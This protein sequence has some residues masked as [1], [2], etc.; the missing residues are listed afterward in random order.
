MSVS[1]DCLPYTDTY[2]KAFRRKPISDLSS[3][4]SFLDSPKTMGEHDECI[5]P[6]PYLKDLIL[7]HHPRYDGPRC[8]GFV[9]FSSLELKWVTLP[10]NVSLRDTLTICQMLQRSRHQNST[11]I[12]RAYFECLNGWVKINSYCHQ[13]ISRPIQHLSCEEARAVCKGRFSFSDN[14]VAVVQRTLRYFFEWLNDPEEELLYGG[15]I[16]Y[17]SVVQII[18]SITLVSVVKQNESMKTLPRATICETDFI[19]VEYSCSQSQSACGDGSCILQHYFCDGKTDCPDDSD[20]IDCHHVCLFS[21]EVRLSN[22]AANCYTDCHY[23]N[24]SCHALYYQCHIAGGCIPASRLCDGKADCAAQEDESECLDFEYGIRATS[25]SP[26]TFTCDDG[27][28]IPISQVNDLIPDC[29]GGNGEDE[30]KMKLYWSGDIVQSP[31][32]YNGCP[33]TYTQC[34]KGLLGVCYPRHKLCVYEVDMDGMQIK[35][36]RNAAHLSNCSSHE[37]PSM[38]KCPLSYCI[39]YHYICNGKLDCPHGEDESSCLAV[40]ECPGLLRCRHDNVCVHPDNVGDKITDC[41]LSADD[42]TLLDVLKCPEPCVC[43][44]NSVLCSLADFHLSNNLWGSITKLSLQASVVD[45][46]F[47]FRMPKLLYLNLSNNEIMSSSFPRWCSLP[48]IRWLDVQNNSLQALRTPM[49]KGLLTLRYLELQMNPIHHIDQFSFADLERLLLLNLSHLRLKHIDI[50]TFSGLS[51]LATLDLSYN[52]LITLEAG[53]FNAFK[54]TLIDLVFIIS[55]IAPSFLNVAPSLSAI[56]NMHVYSRTVCPYVRDKATCHFVKDYTGRCCNFIPARTFEMVMWIYGIVLLI[57]SSV[58]TIFWIFC[59]S[60]KLSKFFM[61]VINFCAGGVSVYPLYILALHY[62]YGSYFLFF[63]ESLA[64][65]FHCKVIGLVFLWCHYTCLFSVLLTRCHNFILVVYPFKDCS[66]I[67]RWF[68][69][70]L[71]V[72]VTSVIL[73]TAVPQTRA[74]LRAITNDYTCQMLLQSNGSIDLWSYISFVLIAA[75][76]LIHA[77]TAIT[78][79]FMSYELVNA[80]NNVQTHGGKRLKQRAS[81]RMAVLGSLEVTCLIIS[82]SIQLLA[83]VMGYAS[84]HILI[85]IFGLLLYEF[86]LPLLHTFTITIFR[87]AIAKVISHL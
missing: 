79:F 65:S 72:L 75:E 39:P 22:R 78:Y 64:T 10:C 6:G 5:H 45:D 82:S 87:E 12:K 26:K 28:L 76:F 27:T 33:P 30:T 40:L 25:L 41:H 71:A 67:E 53:S 34:I 80:G 43:L 46:K 32:E 66:L 2:W 63:R 42:E 49:F 61:I 15:D 85:L 4:A 20:E 50:N 74:E 24:C 83:V 16:N 9:I 13:M 84:D 23:S 7:T 86:L 29:P 38:F 56:T 69:R 59:E 35:H 18:Q 73:L 55:S 31:Y 21:K 81:I 36:C 57:M 37:C 8:A 54:D 68:P 51:S 52:P 77:A 17:C 3:I 70:A 1:D 19:P 47:C 44:G 60:N 62:Y 58:S 14:G 48:H 11:P